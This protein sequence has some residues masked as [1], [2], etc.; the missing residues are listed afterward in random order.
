MSF[1]GGFGGFGMGN[2]L[3]Q[4]EIKQEGSENVIFLSIQKFSIVS[5]TG[6]E[7]LDSPI[8]ITVKTLVH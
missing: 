5:K 4:T 1:G 2:G 7:L 6:F 3:R 8:E